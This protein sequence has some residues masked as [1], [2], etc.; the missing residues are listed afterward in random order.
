[1]SADDNASQPEVGTWKSASKWTN[2]RPAG[3]SDSEDEQD[4]W[5]DAKLIE[6]LQTIYYSD[7]NE[8][9]EQRTQDVKTTADDD[10]RHGWVYRLTFYSGLTF[11]FSILTSFLVF[12]NFQRH[13]E[14][15][16]IELM[17][18]ELVSCFSKFGPTGQIQL[19][20][21]FFSVKITPP[22][23]LSGLRNALAF[24]THELVYI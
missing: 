7:V 10:E 12:F 1:M 11:E 5:M 3:L 4:E 15:Q 8:A 14:N 13:D 18:R 2:I 23:F 9:V 24:T 16:S 19:E 20:Y 22:N 17:C 6:S 21:D